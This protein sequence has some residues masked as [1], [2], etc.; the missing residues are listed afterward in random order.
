MSADTNDASV[1]SDASSVIILAQKTGCSSTPLNY[2]LIDSQST[3]N[4]F[5]N[6]EHVNNV[7]PMAQPINVHCNKGVMTTSTIVD[8]GSNEVYLNKNRIAN[9]LSLFFLVKSITSLITAMIVGVFSRFIHSV[10][11]LNSNQLQKASMLLTLMIIPT[12]LIFLS[13]PL[14]PTRPIYTT[15]L[16]ARI[17]KVSPQNKSSKPTRHVISC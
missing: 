12:Q 5:S 10:A 3:T 1:A 2:L 14:T 15:T 7:H 6:P 17:T 11:S 13:P 9:V 4:L 8:F 16:S